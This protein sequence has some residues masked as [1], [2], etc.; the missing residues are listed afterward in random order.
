MAHDDAPRRRRLTPRAIV[1]NVALLAGLAA[2]IG[3]L[4]WMVVS[5]VKPEG[6]IRQLPPTLMPDQV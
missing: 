4:L 5:S 3:P 6:E 1:L 2:S